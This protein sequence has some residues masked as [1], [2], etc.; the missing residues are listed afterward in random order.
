MLLAERPPPPEALPDR[1]MHP[2]HLPHQGHD[3]GEALSRPPVVGHDGYVAAKL[4]DVGL[5]HH[6]QPDLLEG[7]HATGLAKNVVV[8][9]P[10]WDTEPGRGLRE[11]HPLR[12]Y[13]VD[14]L[15]QL[16]LAP[17]RNVLLLARVV[18]AVVGFFLPAAVLFI[19]LLGYRGAVGAVPAAF[20]DGKVFVDVGSGGTVGVHGRMMGE[21]EGGRRGI[22]FEKA[23]KIR[24]GLQQVLHT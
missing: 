7:P 6:R 11:T 19:A 17:R 14:G 1:Q 10:L 15:A 20:G 12:H 5:L 22:C 2:G 24:L 8:E 3:M 21:E 23:T 13:R 16:R 4:E 9:R 18:V